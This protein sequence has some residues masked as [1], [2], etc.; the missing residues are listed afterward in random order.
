MNSINIDKDNKQE[1]KIR[2]K[3]G[4]MFIMAGAIQKY[5][6]HE[7]PKCNSNDIRFNCCSKRFI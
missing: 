4:S 5:F 3:H 7:I 1:F 2:L 6:S